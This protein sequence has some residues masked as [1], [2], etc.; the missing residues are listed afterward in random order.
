MTT[1][2]TTLFLSISAVL[3]S[4][5]SLG[6]NVYKEL[7]LKPRVKVFVERLGQV[8]VNKGAVLPTPL[9]T[10]GLSAVNFG[11]GEVT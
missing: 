3:I 11:P 6:W 4:F 5:L 1:S 8:P 2:Q 7:R 9:D 10:F